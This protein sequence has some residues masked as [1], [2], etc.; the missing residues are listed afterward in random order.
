MGWPSR[1]ALH[2]LHQGL[3]SLPGIRQVSSLV[4]APAL[5]AS[6][7][8][9]AGSPVWTGKEDAT[10]AAMFGRLRTSL[11][12]R[13]FFFSMLRNM[14]PIYLES[15]PGMAEVELVSRIRDLARYVEQRHPDAGE[16]LVIGPAVVDAGLA[17]HI[18]EDLQ[19]LI[20][21]AIVVVTFGLFLV[22]RNAVFTLLAVSHSLVLLII[23]MGGMV[24][25]GLSVN[26]VSVLAPVIIVPVGVSDLFHLFVRLK[27]GVDLGPGPLDRAGALE[28]AFGHLERAMLGT[29]FTTAIGFLGF[30]ISPVQAI[31]QFGL[32]MSV[33]TMV[34][35]LITFTFDASILA[36]LWRPRVPVGE[37]L[38]RKPP[39]TERLMLNL[40]GST[41]NLRRR[42]QA[43]LLVCS[44]L[45]AIS[46][47]SLAGLRI[48]D[49]WINNFDPGSRIARDIRRFEQ[50]L[51]GSNTLSLVLKADP[52]VPGA[53]A[54]AV[55]A[56]NQLSHSSLVQPGV[57]GVVS[58]TLVA[59]AL[60]PE[61]G[62]PWNPWPTPSPERLVEALKEWE[63]R[64]PPLPRVH[65]LAD[66]DLTRF[67]ILVFIKNRSYPA[68]AR[69]VDTIRGRAEALATTGVTLSV[70][71]DLVANLRMVR[72]AVMSQVYSLAAVLVVMALLTIS[73][74]RSLRYGIV[75][76]LPLILAILV[77]YLFLVAL[78]I[79]YGVAVSMFP[80]LVAGMAIDFAIHFRS[81][82][83]RN[84][85]ASPAV[86][87]RD[88]AIIVHGILVNGTLWAVAFA[89]LA[90]SDLPPNRYLGLLS[91]SG[92][93]LSTVFT[94]LLVPTAALT[95]SSSR[96]LQGRSPV[97]D[98]VPQ[99]SFAD[100]TP[101]GR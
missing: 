26:L 16:F 64:G 3:E 33:G 79:P 74:T 4:N 99:G 28:N 65:M 34:A 75:M 66:P 50:F 92:F 69:L 63:R 10:G 21:F 38:P 39:L 88:M 37:A 45:A 19:R 81:G 40:T 57:Q 6:P 55:D 9:P 95:I 58:A 67:Q 32:T 51:F 43:M 22:T 18:F 41:D 52:S 83:A 96:R 97:P 89:V 71:G 59:R 84:Q 17:D 86:W 44:T 36:L 93:I 7:G 48:E 61:Q 100:R 5:V 54:H 49:T 76:V 87:A 30:L 68:L 31:R 42:S 85:E 90:F 78:R 53:I 20:P 72:L 27:S 47:V 82:L 73:C 8:S 62:M 11:L 60:D 15:D 13:F 23:V 24:S 12:E 35:L 77:T 98:Q 91:S 56:V 14:T 1:A 46:L 25:S 2:E 29:S 101:P 70:G 94:L 80:A